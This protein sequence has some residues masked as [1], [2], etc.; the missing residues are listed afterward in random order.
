M[1]GIETHCENLYPRLAR[2][3]R[4]LDIVVIARSGY[5]KSGTYQGVRVRALWAPRQKG[6]ETFV[7][8]LLSLLYARTF[9]HPD[10]VHLHGVGPG[11]FAPLSRLLGFRTVA[12][13]HAADYERPKWGP[14]AKRVLRT[15]ERLLASS[16]DQIVCVND[17]IART[18]QERYPHARNRTQT[19]RN[20]APPRPSTR[21]ADRDIFTRFGLERGKYVLAVGRLEP[22]KRFHDLVEA[23]KRA[24]PTGKKLV[25]AG[26]TLGDDA[27]GKQL[28]AQQSERVVFTGVLD[29]ATLRL[30]YENCALFVLPSSLEGSPLVALEAMS[31]GAPIALS[32]APANREFELESSLY[33][34]VGDIDALTAMLAHDN[35]DAY[36]SRRAAAILRENDWDEIARKH[37]LVFRRAARTRPEPRRDR[38]IRPASS[39]PLPEARPVRQTA[40]SPANIEQ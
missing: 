27:Y 8:T 39:P 9:V 23:F 21:N 6:V 34:P 5:A 32:D 29:A 37:L 28:L 12:T 38:A 40:K 11:L 15:G 35:F 20:G 18:L 36:R 2:I 33:F 14:I 17:G 10:V 3:D 19:I 7:H 13:H 1:G 16:A 4:D 24:A 31:A 26:A 30:L 25:I 22:T